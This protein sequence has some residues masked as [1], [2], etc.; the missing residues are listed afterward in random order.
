[1]DVNHK[2]NPAEQPVRVWL[3]EDVSA[4]ASDIPE[5]TGL[6]FD[7][8][9]TST[10]KGEAAGDPCGFRSNRVKLVTSA[11]GDFAGVLAQP[12]K[13]KKGATTGLYV[14]VNAPG[15]ICKIQASDAVAALGTK[16]VCSKNAA[17]L[18]KFVAATTETG[19]GVA[20]AL[21]TSTGAGV[22]LAKL[23]GGD[24]NGLKA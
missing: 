10:A 24:Q 15:S 14:Y 17:S 21:Q 13:K 2:N 18:G 1:M 22:I 20:A 6:V 7:Y 3:A 8:S 19:A 9:Y 12:V 4:L 16:L 11:G 23:Y 5:G